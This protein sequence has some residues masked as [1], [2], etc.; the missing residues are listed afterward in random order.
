LV[1]DSGLI[2]D[3]VGLL[4]FLCVFFATY[5]LSDE[6]IDDLTHLFWRE[7]VNISTI[8][9]SNKRISQNSSFFSQL[10]KSIIIYRSIPSIFTYFI[11]SYK[12]GFDDSSSN[13]LFGVSS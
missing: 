13:D 5:P 3:E 10:S 12:M 11:F 1:A 4:S 2:C 6:N 7:M 8:D 9:T